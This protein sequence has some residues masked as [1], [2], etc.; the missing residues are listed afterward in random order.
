[1][2][3]LRELQTGLYLIYL[4]LYGAKYTGHLPGHPAWRFLRLFLAPGAPVAPVAPAG[5]LTPGRPESANDIISLPKGNYIKQI[6]SCAANRF[7]SQVVLPEFLNR[8]PRNFATLSRYC[9]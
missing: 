5:P 4:Y 1:M 9:V 3:R 8:F 6:V 2:R 7:S